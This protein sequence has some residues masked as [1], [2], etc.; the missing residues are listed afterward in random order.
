MFCCLLD[1][2]GSVEWTALGTRPWVCERGLPR[3]HT[4]SWSAGWWR[5]TCL[6]FDRDDQTEQCRKTPVS[7][8]LANS[9]CIVHPFF[10]FPFLMGKNGILCWSNLHV[11]HFFLV[12]LNIFTDLLVI[13]ISFSENVLFT[14]FAHFLI[15]W[16]VF[17][18]VFFFFF[19]VLLLILSANTPLFYILPTFSPKLFM[20]WSLIRFL[21]TFMWSN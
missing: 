11:H 9:S 6:N 3:S 19:F 5:S 16:F 12:S 15:C 4:Q 7:P 17:L 2:L 10:F 13:Y 1:F 20:F 18:F 14:C 8:T 21:F